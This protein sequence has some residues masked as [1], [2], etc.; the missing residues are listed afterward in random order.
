[1][2]HLDTPQRPIPSRAAYKLNLAAFILLPAPNHPISAIPHMLPST[3]SDVLNAQ[4]LAPFATVHTFLPLIMSRKTTMLFL[5]PS[6]NTSLT[7]PSHA[8]ESVVTGGIQNY[9]STLRKEIRCQDV[10][11]VDVKLGHF[12]YETAPGHQQQLVLSQSSLRAEATK[13][14]LEAPGVMKHPVKGSTLRVLHKG[15]FDAIVRGTGRNGTIFIGQG[16]R[17]YDLVGRW[18]PTGVIGWMLGAAPVLVPAPV[19]SIAGSS[20]SDSSGEES[21]ENWETLEPSA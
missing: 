4:L 17:V 11:V 5:N 8:A 2:S 9:I 21:A 14:R 7:A 1:M 10:S 15:V 3:W 6:I 19:A 16:S 12:N 18:I 13:R 20:K